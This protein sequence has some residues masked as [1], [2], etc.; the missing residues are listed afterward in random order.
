MPSEDFFSGRAS[1][2]ARYRVPYPT[3]LFAHIAEAFQLDGSGRLLDLGCGTG[4]VTIP[5]SR[6][7]E[8]TIGLDPSREMV[9]EA[10]AQTPQAGATRI[11]WVQSPVEQISPA[12]GEFPLITAGGPFHWMDREEVL[13]RADEILVPDGGI[14][15][16]DN[17]GSVWSGSDD[18]QQAI[19][20]VIQRWLRQER[21]AGSETSR[22]S[23]HAMRRAL[24]VRPSRSSTGAIM[25]CSTSGTFPRSS[26]CSTQ[27]RSAALP[28]S[29]PTPP[30]S[31]PI[32]PEPSSPSTPP[33]AFSRI[34]SSVTSSRAAPGRSLAWRAAA[35]ELIA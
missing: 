11:R 1:Y 35:A 20:Q 8:E 29:A 3:E 33:A 18:W 23:S 6:W 16:L 26:A 4:Q 2:Y 9:A 14:A 30:P 25:S 22:R 12:L 32:S 17:G 31:R 34:W 7:F 15:L 27:P 28:F 13:R 10:Q 21:R 19:V 24:R 5:L